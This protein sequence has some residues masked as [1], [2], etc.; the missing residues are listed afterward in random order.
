MSAARARFRDLLRLAKTRVSVNARE[1]LFSSPL[2]GDD[3]E[4]FLPIIDERGSDSAMLDN[5]LEMLTLSGR[6]SPTR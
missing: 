2:F 5:V 4:K 3:L 1:S 6:R